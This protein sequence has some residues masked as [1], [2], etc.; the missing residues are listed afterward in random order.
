MLNNIA[1][2]GMVDAIIPIS[3]FNKGEADRIFEEVK[4]AGYKIVMKNNSP[5]CVLV[6]P[7]KYEEMMEQLENYAL[8]IE[9]EARMKNVK[10]S[11]FLSEATILEQLGIKEEELEDSKI[12]IG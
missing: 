9:A 2:Y 4:Q 10:D 5:A 7:E 6:A 12:E 11:E 8:F 3:R 1:I